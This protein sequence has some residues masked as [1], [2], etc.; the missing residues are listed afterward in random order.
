[1]PHKWLRRLVAV[2]V[3]M[4]T[5][6]GGILVTATPA[7]AECCAV[8]VIQVPCPS[9]A[10]GAI[11]TYYNPITV[12]SV[13]PGFL[14]AEGRVVQ[15]DLPYQITVTFTSTITTTFTI[16]A[17]VGVS[18]SKLVEWLTINV[19]STITSA[20][21]VAIGVSTTA[22]VPAFGRVNG[23][24]GVESFHVTFDAEYVF[25]RQAIGGCWIREN[26]GGI[27]RASAS[28]PTYRQGWR[29]Y[30]G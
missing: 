17:S 2:V 22:N 25:R 16:A 4:A 27:T 3:S 19:S 8:R 13:D 20:T 29:V 5:A 6:A 28:A 12:I 7:Q 23:D 26:D 9:W 10:G 11:T 24:Y 14:V 15:N 30:P 1:M 18:I 21:S